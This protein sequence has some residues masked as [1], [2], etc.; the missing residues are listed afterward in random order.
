MSKTSFRL[1]GEQEDGKECCI[2]VV[3][4]DCQ[5]KH[6]IEKIVSTETVHSDEFC[7]LQESVKYLHKFDKSHNTI[8]WRSIADFVIAVEKEMDPEGK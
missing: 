6:E 4:I 8:A 7:C 1:F 5:A 3:E 2:A